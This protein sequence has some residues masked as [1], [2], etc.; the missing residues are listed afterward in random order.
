M[1]NL[2]AVLSPAKRMDLSPSS[3]AASMTDIL[4]PTC[5]EQI[6][7]Q[8]SGW[9]VTEI[10][11]RMSVSESIARETQLRHQAWQW[12]FGDDRKEAI[13]LFQG[14]VYRG[15]DARTLSKKATQHAQSQ[16]RILSG[17]YGV[18]RSTDGVLPY[19]L[20]MG[21]PMTPNQNHK[22]LASF[23]RT[24]VTD[25]LQSSLKPKGVLVNLASEEY[26]CVIDETILQRKIIRCSFMEGGIKKPKVVSTYAKLARGKMA[27]FIL[28]QGMT[29]SEDLKSF[30][31]D[32][33]VFTASLSNEN[34]FIFIR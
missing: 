17:L 14:E 16:L 29:K 24:L 10:Q 15:L 34:H 20:M 5:S 3:N 12:P 6:M 7:K 19:R 31:E 18:M 8:V 25:H 26:S 22:T 27:R 21:T 4:F 13:Y 2:L 28:E 30:H 1:T 9:S 32:G 23:W 11:K 33:Y